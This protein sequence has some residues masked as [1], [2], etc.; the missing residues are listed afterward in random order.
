MTTHE[1]RPT[2][3]YAPVHGLKMYYEITG[4]G[5]PLVYVPPVFG[6]AGLNSFPSLGQ[7]HSVI[8]IDLQGNG[9]TADLP[10]RP[11]S[12]E[13]YA[14]DVIALLRHLGIGK[15]DFLGESYGA[16][17]AI[18]IA[19]TCPELVGRVAT[20]G[21]TFGPPEVAHNPE[22]LRFDRPPT[23]DS[24]CH[25]YQQAKYREVAPDPD[26]WPKIW[27]K[28]ARIQWRGFSDAQLA[29]IQAPVLIAVGDRDF[30]RVEHAVDAFHR[31]PHAELA[32]IPDAGHFALFSE[33]GRVIPL[34]RHFLEKPAQRSPVAT[35]AM[36]YHP[37]ETR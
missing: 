5:D 30:V 3:G 23:P 2:R 15:A 33:P 28:V 22:M 12:I 11:L 35:A 17:T 24:R 9:R 29:S 6:F 34:V 26:Y 31:I 8:T 25:G 21:G 20:Y 1:S 13:Q 14:A 37:G 19:V 16:N 18:M 32:V 27:A 7:G 36:G 4:S 10:E